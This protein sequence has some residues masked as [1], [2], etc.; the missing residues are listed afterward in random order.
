[1]S[2][3]ITH[4]YSRY[5]EALFVSPCLY[6]EM[7]FTEDEVF[8]MH[9]FQKLFVLLF[10]LMYKHINILFQSLKCILLI[11]VSNFLFFKIKYIIKSWTSLVTN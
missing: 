5:R 11:C 3:L 6:F 10:V 8:Q 2:P 4:C 7:I 9:L 1:M